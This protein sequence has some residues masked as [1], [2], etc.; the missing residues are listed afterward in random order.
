M[1]LHISDAP[2][3][4]LGYLTPCSAAQDQKT[5][6]SLRKILASSAVTHLTTIF[7]AATTADFGI[8]G[9]THMYSSNGFVIY[10]HQPFPIL[11]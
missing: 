2:S 6:A 1:N 7:A 10:A 9:V 3:F 4:A 5:G 11:P 8:S